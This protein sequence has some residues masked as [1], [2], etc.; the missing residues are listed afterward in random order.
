MAAFDLR[1]TLR[2][3]AGS[4]FW[5]APE[6]AVRLMPGDRDKRVEPTLLDT[7]FLIS[8]RIDTRK[9]FADFMQT[10]TVAT[11][12]ARPSSAE[13]R[14]LSP[15]PDRYFAP[16]FSVRFFSVQPVESCGAAGAITP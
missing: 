12:D 15:H 4:L 10:A 3:R 7:P 8:P 2:Y 1:P 6:L 14:V 11:S 13:L 5:K 9:E 16:N